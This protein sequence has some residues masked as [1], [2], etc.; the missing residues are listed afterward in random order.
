MREKQRANFDRLLKPAQIAF[1]GGTDAA[2]AIVEAQRRDFAGEI[3]P[4]NPKRSEMAGVPCFASLE[5]L[6]SAPDAVFLAIPPA[7]AIGAIKTLSDMGAGGVVCYTA[8]FREAGDKGAKLEEKLLEA[9]GNMVLVGPNCYGM[10][11][12]LDNAALWPFA[13]GGDCP[14]YGAAVI[15]QSGMF[16]S[17]ITMSRRSLP[18]THMISAG[19]Q[20]VLALE[21]FV[22]VLSENPAVRAIGLHIEGLQD[23]AQFERAA[24]NAIKGGTPIVAFK[25]G[26]SKIGSALT[27]SH[28]GSLSGA[29]ELYDA[30]FDRCG[31]I[32]VDSP[33]QFIETLKYL[34]VVSA[35]KGKNVIGFTCSGGGATMLADHSETIGLTYPQF[36][37]T[38]TAVLTELLPDIATVSNPLDYTTPIWG[39]PEYTLP[40][41]TEAIARAGADAAI[42][43]QDYPAAGLDETKPVYIAD[44]IAFG[45][46]AKAAGIPAAICSTI[47]ENMDAAT[48]A[49]L[50]E[51][52]IAPM[53][54]IHEALNAIAQSSKWFKDRVRI[55]AE[56]PEPLLNRPMPET[57]KM[58][59]EA[60][61]KNVLRAA[62]MSVP[63]GMMVKGAD[64]STAAEKLGF[65]VVVKLMSTKLAHKTEAGAVT[66]GLKDAQAVDKAVADMKISVA[67]YDHNIASDDFLVE[68]MVDPP[69]AEMIVGIRR[70]P[71]FG[72]A[73]MIGSGGILVELLAD[74]DTL[75]LPASA[76]DIK[77][78]ISRLKLA[79][80]LG[81]FR[82]KPA[83]DLDHLAKTLAALG[84]YAM[85]NAD[86]I[87]EIEINPL[88]VYQNDARAVDALVHIPCCSKTVAC[89]EA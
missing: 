10:I 53:Q 28:T 18:L 38:N 71:Q 67:R 9:V 14:G 78:S 86:T 39:Q 82:G 75:V 52:G 40:V 65:P 30:L 13:H 2:V 11:N 74:T 34:C 84:D 63:D 70:H 8:G 44:A 89:A 19:N 1:V 54:G 64:A 16:S 3:W 7:F 4:V 21:D 26:K 25:T 17:D 66:L 72:L 83:V 20:S 73:M 33:S 57:I 37:K 36:D 80:L 58:I 60:G 46:A 77:R 51:N 55:L 47:H 68:R 81:G 49:T 48:R 42:L 62:G 35:P 43:V 27:Q 88:F 32:A 85:A 24:L 45:Q 12:Y 50:I 69:I 22:E 15:T 5:D 56:M 79:K 41:F 76:A 87:A 23:V 61:S 6:P 59:H 31:V 29:K